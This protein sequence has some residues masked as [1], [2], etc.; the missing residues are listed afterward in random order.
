MRE[1]DP[2]E[3][4][5]EQ[6][7]ARHAVRSLRA[8]EPD[9]DFPAP[10][11]AEFTA[12]RFGER[13]LRLR[14][15]ERESTRWAAASV[16]ATVALVAALLLN[17]GP[18]WRVASS[19]GEGIAVVDGRPVPIGHTTD[20]NRWLRP[21]ATVQ[22][23]DGSDLEIHSPGLLAIQLSPGTRFSIPDVPGRWFRRNVRAEVSGG[24]ARITTASNFH[25]ARLE[26]RTPEAQIE[27]IG[28]TLAV[29]CEPEGTCVCVLEGAVR[30]G[31][32]GQAMVEVGHGSRRYVFADSR[33]AVSDL[34]RSTE[35]ARLTEFRESR[36]AALERAAR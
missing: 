3:P 20:F 25:G 28:T 29:I 34:I 6:Q 10:L 35:K 31:G 11:R 22:I 32:Q 33:P 18:A 14:W 21:G 26:I 1:S 5:H 4:A 13:P 23:P 16:A 27:V 24:E 36:R 8:L 2:E 19:H 12:G 7:S 30:V 15:W 17:Q 9:P